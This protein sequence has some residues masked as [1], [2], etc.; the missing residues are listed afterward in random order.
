MSFDAGDQADVAEVV[1]VAHAAGDRWAA[2]SVA[3]RVRVLRA[4]RG[5]LWRASNDLA[6]ALHEGGLSIDEAMLEV[7][8]S[9]EHLKWVEANAARVLNATAQ[10][11]GLLSPELATRTSYGA[12]GVVAVIDRKSVV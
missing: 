2:T 7:L 9:I 1:R 10:G 8:Q 3:E 12:E 4:W 5:R 6:G 11:A